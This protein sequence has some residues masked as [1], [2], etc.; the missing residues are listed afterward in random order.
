[1]F[2]RCA[3]I[4]LLTSSLLSAAD[5]QSGQAARAVL[6]QSSFS[7][8]GA[9]IR[10][11]SMTLSGGELY[12]ADAGHHVF[13]FDLSELPDALQ[14]FALRSATGCTVCGFKPA[15][16]STQSVSPGVAR[17][18]TWG[19]SVAMV[20]SARHRVRFWRDSRYASS[21][22][23]LGGSGAA[24]V[25]GPATL[26]DPVSVAIDGRRLFVGDAA[27]HRVLVWNS[28]PTVDD[29]P[30]D[31]VLGQPASASL[32][33]ADSPT[34]DSIDSPSAL[35][36]DGNNLFVADS[37][38]RRILVFSPAEKML[39]PDAIVNSASF[40]G[41]PF[42]PGT[43]ISISETA[44]GALA[45]PV[46][47]DQS[48]PLPRELGGLQ[49]IFDGEA[50]PLLSVSR[51]RSEAQLPYD[52]GARTAASFYL[53][54]RHEDGTV[55]STAPVALRL[56]AISPGLFAF[57]GKEPRGGILLHSL[58]AQSGAG[59]PVTK[60]TPVKPG[61]TVTVLATG[62]GAVVDTNPAE[63]LH[64]GVPREARGQPV[65][66]PLRAQVNDQ[67][68]DVVFAR[69]L[70]EA[71]GVYEIGIVISDQEMSGEA[72]LRITANGYHSNTV[73][74]PVL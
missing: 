20:D 32:D 56:S 26:T 72:R 38:A 60:Q 59:I 53:R 36:S 40:A 18:S 31:A 55:S 54:L 7:S 52:F 9:G 8:R 30:A 48:Q 21:E 71:I 51:Q 64:A 61:E 74:F 63:V 13:T 11:T 14:N 45:G 24:S 42:A 27:L 47:A 5:F 23:L 29:Q 17:Y 37:S 66:A 46:N 41:G 19:R 50:I 62:L 15:L 1:M 3:A 49:A 2:Y 69:L 73:T 4:L 65:L 58:T 10:I 67:A 68:A 35:A 12:V 39:R 6:G 25:V 22:I 43:L 44:L 33:S 70:P 16:V 34:P 28:L 57:G